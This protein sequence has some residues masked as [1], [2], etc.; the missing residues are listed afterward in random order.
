MAHHGK[1]LLIRIF[2]FFSTQNLKDPVMLC[3]DCVC[4]QDPGQDQGAAGATGQGERLRR[5]TRRDP[6]FQL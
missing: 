2:Y 6:S 1:Q 4:L 3:I 5:N